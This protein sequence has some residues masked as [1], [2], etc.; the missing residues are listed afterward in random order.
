[1]KTFLLHAVL[2]CSFFTLGGCKQDCIQLFYKPLPLVLAQVSDGFTENATFSYRNYA[3]TR[4]AQIKV[5]NWQTQEVADGENRCARWN[6]TS[7]TIQGDFLL[8]NQP[9]NVRV[10]NFCPERTCPPFVHWATKQDTLLYW[11]GT[12]SSKSP[13]NRKGQLVPNK[14]L[15]I[16]GTTFN[17][18]HQHPL[19]DS[20]TLWLNA[21]GI[22]Q[23]STYI[24]GQLDTFYV[25]L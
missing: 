1:M 14:T 19:T 12:Y 13:E 18:V 11:T 23:F 22:V 2:V 9:V 4:V 5:L 10:N 20:T 16:K 8:D 6:E 3:G 15:E 25:E 24:S 21:Q 17:S 7:F